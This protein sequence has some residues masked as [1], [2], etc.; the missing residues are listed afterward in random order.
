[1]AKETVVRVVD[2]LDGSKADQTV[3]FGFAGKSYEI[4]LSKKNAGVLE[5][6]LKPYIDVARS[7][8][9]ASGRGRVA[10]SRTSRASTGVDLGA[11]REWARANGFEV[12]D[13]GRVPAAI[14]EAY[15]TA[16]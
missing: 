1:M 16:Q 3:S 9:S 5:K 11:V 13:R 14:L 12:N 8:R 10:S 6:V 7:V 15:G 2:D 4:D